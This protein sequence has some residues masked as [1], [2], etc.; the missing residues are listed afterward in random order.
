M[1]TC[2]VGKTYGCGIVATNGGEL[3]PTSV[4]S[5]FV[6]ATVPDAPTITSVTR[7]PSSAI[8][9][10]VIPADTTA[11]VTCSSSDGG[12]TQFNTGTSAPITV[13]NLDLGKTYTCSALLTNAIGDSDPSGASDPFVAATHPG[14]VTDVAAQVATHGTTITVSLTPGGDGF[15]TVDSWT[16]TCT[17][18]D[19]GAPGNA[20]AGTLPLE[21][22]NLTAGSH[23]TCE[24]TAHNAIGDSP[25]SAPSNE[26]L[27]PGFTVPGAP[28]GVAAVSQDGA[29][30]VSFTAPAD[31]GGHSIFDYTATCT[32]SNGGATNSADDA[33]SP[34]TVSGLTNGAT[35]TCTVIASSDAGDSR[36][37]TAS[38]AAAPA[39][40]PGAPGAPAQPIVARASHSVTVT[41][42]APFAGESAITGY[43]ATCESGDGGD[44]G[45]Q[46]GS[47]SPI[48]VSGL[49]NGKHYTCTVTATNTQGLGTSSPASDAVVVGAVPGAPT[50]VAVTRTSPASASV[51][52]TPGPNDGSA[53]TAYRGQC[54]SSDG[55]SPNGNNSSTLPVLVSNL[56]VGKHYTCVG[57]A[58]N[59]EGMSA[60]S[61]P[62][63][64]FVA[65]S[66]PDAPDQPSITVLHGAASV[67]ASDGNN[68]G[69]PVTSYH[70]TCTSTDGGATKSA[71]RTVQPV[72]VSGLDDGKTYTC[73]L[74]ATNALGD[75]AASASSDPF[76]P[77][78]GIPEPPTDVSAVGDFDT[79]AI[80]VEF[81]ELADGG[82]PITSF[83]VTCTSTNGGTTITESGASSP[84]DVPGGTPGKFYTCTVTATSDAGTST[85]SAPSNS[86][87]A[88]HAPGAPTITQVRRRDD[89]VLLDF[90]EGTNAGTTVTGALATCTSSDGGATQTSSNWDID[91][92]VSSLTRGKTYTCSVHTTNGGG[93]SPESTPTDPFTV[94]GVPSAPTVTAVGNA[95]SDLTVAFSTPTDDGG[96]AITGYTATCTSSN[97]GAAGAVSGSASPITVTGLTSGKTYTCTVAAANEAG[98]SPESA[99]SSAISIGGAPNVTTN[100][101]ITGTLI[102]QRTLT[103]HNG[104]WSGSPTPTITRQWKRCN[105]TLTSCSNIPGASHATYVLTNADV[106]KRIRLTVTAH[107]SFGT[108]SVGT[109]TGVIATV[110]VSITGPYVYVEGASA[111]AGARGNRWRREPRQHS[112]DRDRE[113]QRVR[114]A[115]RSRQRN[116]HRHQVEEADRRHRGNAERQGLL[117]VRGRRWRVHVRR[118]A[119][120]RLN[121]RNPAQGSDHLDDRDARRQGVLVVRFRRRR[122]HVRRRGLLRID[123]RPATRLPSRRDARDAVRSRLLARHHGRT[124]TPFR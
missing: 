123:G 104:T 58:F 85:P 24:A 113:W 19:G 27:V 54:N 106:G 50:D 66:A 4:P 52:M 29:L 41:F 11:T 90:D 111:A 8:V 74:L 89:G 16:A 98:M 117:V 100:P 101:S 17:S 21:V 7:G 15:A 91:I 107:N 118:R 25:N 103:A 64:E 109:N 83:D 6:A 28:T 75:G 87:T 26:V 60:A 34:I 56:T 82:S 99:S 67:T 35:Y 42:T 40:I 57:Y 31:D 92:L 32:S 114:P 38:N 71:T 121:R 65:A 79:G 47:S 30:S 62:S 120:L 68:G 12:T 18:D 102:A 36:A 97:G 23:Y 63:A 86:A 13:S 14:T 116:A 45:V 94:I 51:D 119:L 55:G 49:T 80:H 76:V 96:S 105:A 95:G 46:P 112:V 48:T 43:T 108:A 110:P 3:R 10:L 72:V 53:V 73:T 84:I 2:S 88:D 37:S 39:S 124:R 78:D 69:A 122:L 5:T 81:A 115:L 93:D 77:H 59:A 70:A 1:P 44:P 33:T 9:D 61:D 20:T 22:D